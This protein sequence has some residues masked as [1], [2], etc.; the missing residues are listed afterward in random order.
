METVDLKEKIHCQVGEWKDRDYFKPLKEKIEIKF[1]LFMF[2][3]ELHSVVKSMTIEYPWRVTKLHSPLQMIPGEKQKVSFGVV[4]ISEWD[5]G[6]NYGDELNIHYGMEVNEQLCF[7]KV[8]E[9]EEMM[10]VK[11]NMNYIIESMV[12]MME[13]SDAFY[14][15][16]VFLLLF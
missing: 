4:N 2:Y 14:R 6:R 5:Y 12:C 10:E 8:K 16:S 9:K 1:T 13:G 11:S 15:K 3:V 7:E